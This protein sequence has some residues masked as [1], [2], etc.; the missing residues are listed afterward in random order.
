MKMTQ[1]GFFRVCFQP[2]TTL[3]CCTTCIS[4]GSYNAHNSPAIMNIRTFVPY[5]SRNPQNDFPKMR[6]GGSKAVWNFSKVLSVLV[7]APVPKFNRSPNHLE[8]DFAHRQIDHKFSYLSV[9][10]QAGWFNE[11]FSNKTFLNFCSFFN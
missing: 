5:L 11:G 6:G 7:C 2:I 3:N 1:R 4:I 8:M 9:Y 10:L